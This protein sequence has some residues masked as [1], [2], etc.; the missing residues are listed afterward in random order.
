LP[1][2]WTISNCEDHIERMLLCYKW[3]PQKWGFKDNGAANQWRDYPY[4]RREGYH[5]P[6]V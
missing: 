4:P 1:V 2:E 5:L 6:K 3:Y